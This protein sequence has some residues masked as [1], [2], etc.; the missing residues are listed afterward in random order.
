MTRQLQR[1][2]WWRC[3]WTKPGL[4]P[5]LGLSLDR[6]PQPKV[7]EPGGQRFH[8]EE[9]R[10]ASQERKRPSCG[11]EELLARLERLLPEEG[12]KRDTSRQKQQQLGKYK[13]SE[14]VS[15]KHVNLEKNSKLMI[16]NMFWHRF[17]L[18]KEKKS[19]GLDKKSSG[20]DQLVPQYRP[21]KV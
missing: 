2:L 16:L 8:P 21:E 14:R 11:R 4:E 13:R 9:P 18:L 12:G 6:A 17:I 19:Y 10:R 1:T 20:S 3:L 7:L 5:L 15:E